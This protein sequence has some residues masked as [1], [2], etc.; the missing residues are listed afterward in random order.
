MYGSYE[1]NAR[2][3]VYCNN[4]PLMFVDP[5]GESATVVGAIVGGGIGGINALIRRENVVA[6]IVSGGVSG[7]IAGAFVGATVASG[8]LVVVIGGAIGGGIG[9]GVGDFINQIGNFRY[10][11]EVSF[12]WSSVL[13]STGWGVVFGWISGGISGLFEQALQSNAVCFDSSIEFIGVISKMLMD[14]GVPLDTIDDI[15]KNLIVNLEQALGNSS[16]RIFQF[17]IFSSVALS[18]IET[19]VSG[20]DL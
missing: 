1:I 19:I 8:G 11:Q 15:S 13:N 10:G 18:T 20:N 6:G 14:A 3:Y 9:S 5:D 4:N 17:D 12:N 7:A 16:Q 2:Y